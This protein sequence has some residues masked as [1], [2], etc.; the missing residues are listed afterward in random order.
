MCVE[1]GTHDIKNDGMQVANKTRTF[2]VRLVIGIQNKSFFNQLGKQFMDL[3]ES[4]FLHNSVIG[5]W[6]PIKRVLP[7]YL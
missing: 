4:Y 3:A 2:F 1:F 5:P 6:A 7:H